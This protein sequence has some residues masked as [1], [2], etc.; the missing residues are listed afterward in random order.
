MWV[1]VTHGKVITNQIT[2]KRGNKWAIF[3]KSMTID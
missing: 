1:E 3:N 2:K